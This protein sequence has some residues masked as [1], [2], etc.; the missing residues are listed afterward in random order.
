MPTQIEIKI[1]D[2]PLPFVDIRLI[3]L[4]S[5]HLYSLTEQHCISKQSQYSNDS[6]MTDTHLL[7]M[8]TQIFVKLSN[9]GI[10]L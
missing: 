10:M 5:L 6:S 3:I 8:L 4:V 7:S 9:P 1:F 2:L